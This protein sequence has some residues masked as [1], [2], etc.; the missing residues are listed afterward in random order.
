MGLTERSRISGS[1]DGD[2]PSR[3]EFRAI[4]FIILLSTKV[5]GLIMLMKYLRA[6]KSAPWYLSLSM[7]P[8]S[9][10]RDQ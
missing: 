4:V 8:D 2:D 1:M 3:A 10:G 7:P 5:L 9:H 6:P